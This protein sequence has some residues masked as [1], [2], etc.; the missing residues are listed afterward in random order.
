MAE[1][2]VKINIEQ[3]ENDTYLAPIDLFFHQEFWLPRGDQFTQ[4]H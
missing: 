4:V 1:I 3:L 2:F